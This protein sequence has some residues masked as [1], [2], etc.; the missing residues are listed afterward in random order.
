MM[1]NEIQLISDGDGLAVVGEPTAV[2]RFLRSEGLWAAS[3]GFDLRRLTSLLGLGSD[4]AQA[5]SEITANSGRW[6]KLTEESARLV[7]EHGLMES[8][9]PGESHLMVGIPGAVKSWLQAETGPASALTNP[10]VLAG[11]AGLMA[12]AARQQT[13]AEITDYL[14]RIDEKVDD[15]LGKVDGTVL[16]DMRGARLQIRR[17]MTMREQEGRVTGDAWSE[18]QNASGKLADV[19]GYALLQLETTAEKLE[20]KTRTG[21]L[22]QAT[23]EAR[24][25]VRKWLAVLADCFQLQDAFDVL[26]LDRALDESADAVAARRR[27]LE[28]DRRDRLDLIARHTEHLLGRMDLAVGRANATMVWTRTKSLAVIESG[29]H[30]AAGVHEFHELLGVEADRRSWDARKLGPVVSRSAQAIQKTKDAAPYAATVVTVAGLAAAAGQ[31]LQD[32]DK[33]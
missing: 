11:V 29:N 18:V 4:V 21:G 10:A 22:A 28:A 7:K 24:P 15:V 32:R 17:A 30:L 3:K 2:E 16:K 1:D 26:A 9:T 33:G 12:Q 8:K 27:G 14:V 6:I 25:E 5:A 23:E 13:M 19:Q 31:K 20:S